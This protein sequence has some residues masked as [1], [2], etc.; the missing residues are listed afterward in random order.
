MPKNVRNDTLKAFFNL[1]YH[2]TPSYTIGS[3]DVDSY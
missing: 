1:H 3:I 2:L